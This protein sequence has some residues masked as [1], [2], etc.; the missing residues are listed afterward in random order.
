MNRALILR[1]LSC[2]YC[3]LSI[4]DYDQLKLKF[5]DKEKS[6]RKAI[7]HHY[8]EDSPEYYDCPEPPDDCYGGDCPEPPDD[9][10]GGDCPEPPD[11]CYEC[12]CPDD[13]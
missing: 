5:K 9:C 6:L 12:D 3:G 4:T 11:D 2:H 8:Q 13:C 7:Y 10:Y 1:N